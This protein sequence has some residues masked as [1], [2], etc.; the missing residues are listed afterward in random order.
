[1]YAFLRLF[2]AICSIIRF[3]CCVY[4]F[5]MY[6]KCII[7]ENILIYMA[8]EI[9]ILYIYYLFILFMTYISIYV[10]IFFIFLELLKF[11]AE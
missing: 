6:L 4:T 11:L 1:M 9:A 7:H 2:K 5:Y 10:K 3:V 8:N